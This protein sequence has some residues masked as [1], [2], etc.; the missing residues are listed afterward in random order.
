M[1]IFCIGVNTFIDCTSNCVLTKSHLQTTCN[2][3]VHPSFSSSQS[4]S[5]TGTY[6]RTDVSLYP[7]LFTPSDTIPVCFPVYFS[8]LLIVLPLYEEYFHGIQDVLSDL[9]VRTQRG[10]ETPQSS[11]KKIRSRLRRDLG[12]VLSR[13]PLPFLTS[14][15][16][17]TN[18][19]YRI[20]VIFRGEPIR[21]DTRCRS[22]SPDG[23][24]DRNGGGSIH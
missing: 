5:G 2:S 21:V 19:G 10:R 24:Q 3:E 1:F 4:V 13:L 23:T 20:F 11:Y 18:S 8:G 17:D 14:T 6:P 9:C 22:V 16:I 7:S 12:V 15:V